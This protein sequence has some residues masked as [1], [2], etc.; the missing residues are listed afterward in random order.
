MRAD[1]AKFSSKTGNYLQRVTS[2]FL[3][4]LDA[5]AEG[6]YGEHEYAK[7]RL[8]KRTVGILFTIVFGQRWK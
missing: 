5:R 7:P 8:V 3:E 2:Y 1:L 4:A 6:T